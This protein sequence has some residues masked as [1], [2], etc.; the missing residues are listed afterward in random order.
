MLKLDPENERARAQIGAITNQYVAWAEEALARKD[1]G[2]AREMTGK[3][4]YV[5]EQA[6]EVGV[7]PDVKRRLE[8][9][10]TGLAAR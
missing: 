3:A 8:A 1:R 7:T 5:V 2:R 10:S 9:L 4:T 6:T